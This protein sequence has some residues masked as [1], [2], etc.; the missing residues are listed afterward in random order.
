MSLLT[1]AFSMFTITNC[2]ATEKSKNYRDNYGS[3]GNSTMAHSSVSNIGTSSDD[4]KDEALRK[5]VNHC[6]NYNIEDGK[7]EWAKKAIS[8]QGNE[9]SNS[10]SNAKEVIVL[11][12]KE[13]GYSDD[14]SS[15]MEAFAE[16][17]ERA[18]PIFSLKD[19]MAPMKSWWYE[20]VLG[21]L[22]GLMFC[23]GMQTVSLNS[24]YDKYK[25]K[26]DADGV[27]TLFIIAIDKVKKVLRQ[28]Q[29]ANG[30]ESLLEKICTDLFGEYTF[31]TVNELAEYLKHD[32]L[33][34][35]YA[36][37][38]VSEQAMHENKL[39]D[40]SSTETSQDGGLTS[41]EKNKTNEKIP[42]VLYQIKHIIEWKNKKENEQI[43]LNES[44]LLNV[45][46][47]LETETPKPAVI[48]TSSI[49]DTFEKD[50]GTIENAGTKAA[51]RK[52]LLNGL[53]EKKDNNEFNRF[54]A[55]IK[56]TVD[57]EEFL[58]TVITI[59]TG[60]TYPNV[61]GYINDVNNQ[62]KNQTIRSLI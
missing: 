55:R 19:I 43:E 4:K 57:S 2:Y 41:V 5:I 29:R 37:G 34:Y 49:S 14:H 32:F 6:V 59:D 7:A 38:L 17:I 21:L 40:N 18:L 54:Y 8:T 58:Q 46:K 30:K 51:M 27:N 44:S 1:A 23:C 42:S 26:L 33:V 28:K 52:I 25:Y 50:I 16:S 53:Y 56:E 12:E 62:I 45:I 15:R 61:S 3:S 31:D 9:W 13:P 20:N 10:M 35:L 47:N 22:N 11:Y 48:A 36:C 24:N 60:C 39:V